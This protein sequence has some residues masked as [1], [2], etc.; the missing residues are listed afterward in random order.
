MTEQSQTSL[1]GEALFFMADILGLNM[2][3]IHVVVF[4]FVVQMTSCL[5]SLGFVDFLSEHSSQFHELTKV[6]FT[7]L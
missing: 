4:Q 2:N 6:S 1:E 5:L 7:I 3:I